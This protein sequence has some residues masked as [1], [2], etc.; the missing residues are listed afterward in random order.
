MVRHWSEDNGEAGGWDGAAPRAFI[1]AVG[2]KAGGLGL[3]SARRQHRDRGVVGKDR[4]PRQNMPPDGVGQ[5]FQQGG[6]FADPIRQ[7]RAIQIEPIALEDLALAVEWQ[8]VGILV[9]Q[10]MRQ[11]PG[12]GTSTLDRPRRQRCLREAI[13][14]GTGH[15]GS[16]RPAQPDKSSICARTRAGGSRQSA[17]GHI[18][19]LRSHLRPTG[20]ACHRTGRTL[21]CPGSVRPP[22]AEYDPGSACASACRRVYHRADAAWRLERRW[23][24]RSSPAPVA[25][26]RMSRRMAQT[27]GRVAQPTDAAAS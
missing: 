13:A 22:H 5:R 2:P 4:L 3:A 9:D 27:D 17:R 16:P 15:P 25:T 18:P 26:A 24:S 8:M 12:A 19:V 10:N 1:P 23:Q 14:A 11:Q 6:G 20:E 7:R 21:Y